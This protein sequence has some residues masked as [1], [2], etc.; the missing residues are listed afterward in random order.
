MKH[1]KSKSEFTKFR[2]KL[3]QL[4]ASDWYESVLSLKDFSQ[5][6]QLF[7]GWYDAKEKDGL[8]HGRLEQVGSK[9]RHR[10]R[11]RRRVTLT[12]MAS[13]QYVY[14]QIHVPRA[15][16]GD[17]QYR[18]PHKAQNWTDPLF[19]QSNSRVISRKHQKQ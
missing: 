19:S 11:R 7:L 1:S 5:K 17:V 10:H 2:I 12:K 18:T 8:G 13:N 3:L 14:I 15:S 16:F 4:F 6:V 9:R